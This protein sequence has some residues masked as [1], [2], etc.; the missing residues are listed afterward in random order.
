MNDPVAVP[1]L[2]YTAFLAILQGVTEFLPVSSSGHLAAA[3]QVWPAMA[4]PGEVFEIAVHLGTTAA[5]LV[6]YRHMLMGLLRQLNSRSAI[7]VWLVCASRQLDP[8]LSTYLVLSRS[9]LS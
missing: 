3:Q 5:V 9:Q 1:S 4:F 7:A 2:L 8:K 6:Y